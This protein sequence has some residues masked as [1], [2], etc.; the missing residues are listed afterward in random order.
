MKYREL[1]PEELGGRF[2][3]MQIL[4]LTIFGGMT[5]VF[6]LILTLAYKDEIDQFFN[7]MVKSWI[8]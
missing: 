3:H 4:A 1:K 8:F 7:Q 5:I 6:G 2:N